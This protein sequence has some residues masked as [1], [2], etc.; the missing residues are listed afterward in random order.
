MG[1]ILAVTTPPATLWIVQ[2]G[3]RRG[4]GQAGVVA[5][6]IGAG[7]AF[8]AVGTAFCFLLVVGFW[9]YIG[10]PARA[11]ALLILGYMAWRCF[12]AEGAKSLRLPLEVSVPASRAQL[13]QQTF[14]ILVTMP[15]RI[16]VIVAYIIAT[17]LLYRFGG[18]GNLPELGVG[19]GLGTLAWGAFIALLGGW[20]GDRVEDSIILKSLNKLNRFA[21]VIFA[22]LMVITVYPLLLAGAR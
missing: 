7:H 21:A 19:T 4:W 16:P 22:A 6:A 3:F 17:A 18:F 13:F 15:M 5:A 1:V 10:L 11:L 9:R 12:W 8:L 20:V 2:V 14:Y